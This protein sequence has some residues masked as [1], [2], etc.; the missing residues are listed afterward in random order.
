MMRIAN[1][2]TGFLK[3]LSG[4]IVFV[5]AASWAGALPSA[6]FGGNE[7]EAVTSVND[8]VY[9]ELN[10]G[11]DVFDCNG[12]IPVTMPVLSRDAAPANYQQPLIVIKAK[13]ASI[14][15]G[16][17][18]KAENR[19]NR[20][21]VL[22]IASEKDSEI[23]NGADPLAVNGWDGTGFRV[24]SP[25]GSVYFPS[26]SALSPANVKLADMLTSDSNTSNCVVKSF[27]LTKISGTCGK[28]RFRIDVRGEGTC[29]ISSDLIYYI[30]SNNGYDVG[31]TTYNF[32]IN[33]GIYSLPSIEANPGNNRNYDWFLQ[34]LGVRVGGVLRYFGGKELY[35]GVSLDVTKVGS[36]SG[37]KTAGKEA[38]YRVRV[39]DGGQECTNVLPVVK[40]G[41]LRSKDNEKSDVSAQVNGE[42]IG[43]VSSSGDEPPTEFKLGPV[44][45]GSEKGAG[46]GFDYSDFGLSTL[47]ISVVPGSGSRYADNRS[48]RRLLPLILRG[49]AEI[50]SFPQGIC[51]RYSQE[52]KNKLCSSGCELIRSGEEFLLDILPVAYS[53]S[54]DDP[55]ACSDEA[56]KSRV[57]P[58]FRMND[59]PLLRTISREKHENTPDPAE[60]RD[61]PAEI[62]TMQ[63]SDDTAVSGKFD[64]GSEG[65]LLPDGMKL[66]ARIGSAGTF[67]AHIPSIEFTEE[68][69]STESWSEELSWIYPYAY[70][71]WWDD[72]AVPS[73][74]YAKSLSFCR[75]ADSGSS[76]YPW[77]TYAGQP[78][79]LR[80]AR[81]EAINKQGGV[82][83]NYDSSIFSHATDVPRL[84][85]FAR[86]G[87]E[88]LRSAETIERLPETD[89][90][91]PG[92][93]G[94]TDGWLYTRDASS[95]TAMTHEYYFRLLKDGL[96]A[97]LTLYTGVGM[98]SISG[99]GR[100]VV[101]GLD[102]N[103]ERFSASAPAA[104]GAEGTGTETPVSAPDEFC[105]FGGK[106]AYASMN[107]LTGRLRAV[108]GRT[109]SAGAAYIPF[110]AEYVSG[111]DEGGSPVWTQN[112]P[113]SCTVLSFG[114][115]AESPF[116]F[117]ERIVSESSVKDTA[118]VSPVR[119]AGTE[120]DASDAFTVTPQGGIPFSINFSGTYRGKIENSES[121]APESSVF[122]RMR[123]GTAVLRLILNGNFE[124]YGAR[125]ADFRYV[126]KRSTI[127]PLK[128]TE[129]DTFDLKSAESP[130]WLGDTVIGSVIF[131]GRVVSPRMIYLQDG[132]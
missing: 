5:S 71:I 68:L 75:K 108:S 95:N 88:F 29:S 98:E 16:C 99:T 111:F 85:P 55:L 54:D 20:F 39:M 129:T 38:F 91:A 81:I 3:T 23:V 94:W 119:K 78:F 104:E 47:Y 30:R 131:G 51:V 10:L 27:V 1:I 15:E 56:V 60:D 21:D 17:S 97:P 83:K 125:R 72:S 35:D 4:L 102:G 124:D 116:S 87:T 37:E 130:L 57:L 73:E 42:E 118:A 101:C 9:Y 80:N 67:R 45:S 34:A 96:K 8:Y 127:G 18:F 48:D 28:R 120:H 53:G 36:E 49:S 84:M 61:I 106:S 69:K 59:I 107:F 114:R 113:D 126:L 64:Y 117:S 77:F 74:L 82:I 132:N 26:D 44:G 89:A 100:S 19:N 31:K 58:S 50:S 65:S 52:N 32:D 12:T 86:E 22:I 14:S 79:R 112:Y 6:R 25:S 62:E 109:G 2:V 122:A 105:A 92:W 123:N 41:L 103:G 13:K 46:F 40:A 24:T 70:R 66:R 11:T 33:N 76:K 121:A 43:F 90:A 63:G 110:V 115:D 93:Q 7:L 128:D